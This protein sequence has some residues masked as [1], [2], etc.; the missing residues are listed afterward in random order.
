MLKKVQPLNGTDDFDNNNTDPVFL[1]KFAITEYEYYSK[2]EANQLFGCNVAGLLK[3]ITD[4]EGSTEIYTYDIYGNTK[5]YQNKS[6][7]ITTYEYNKVGWKTKEITPNQEITS[8]DY[9]KN[10]N[11][12][13]QKNPDGGIT[14]IVYDNAGYKILEVTPEQYEADKDNLQTNQY[15]GLI[16]TK[17]KWYD[18]GYLEYTEDVYGNRTTYTYDKFGNKIS[19]LR[20]NNAYY[21][22]E[23]DVLNRPTKIYFK[24]MTQQSSTEILLSETSYSILPNGNSQKT[25]TSFHD[26]DGLSKSTTTTITDY[27]GRVVEQ[28]YPDLTRTKTIYNYDGTVKEKISVNGSSTIYKYDGMGRVSD[29]WSAASIKDGNI[30]YSWNNFKYDKNGNILEQKLGKQLVGINEATDDTYSVSSKYNKGQLIEQTDSDGKKTSFEYDVNDNVKKEIKYISSTETKLTQYQYNYA[31]KPIVVISYVRNGDIIGSAFNDNSLK[32][33]ITQYIYDKNGNVKSVI[34]PDGTV[35]ANTYDKLNRLLSTSVTDNS[36]G[37]TKSITTSKIYNWDSTV[38]A[39]TD[40]NGNIT[41][42]YYDIMGNLI[43]I[44]DA[45]NNISL[46]KYD[47]AG[48]KIAEVS[49]TNVTDTDINSMERTEYTYD[50]MGRVKTKAVVFKKWNLN[51]T[52]FTWSKDWT[53]A[54][55]AAYAYDNMS[56]VIKSLDAMGFAAGTGTTDNEKIYTGYGTTNT[57]T[58]SGQ[59]ETTKD[60][61]AEFNNLPYTVKYEYNGLGQKIKETYADN[62]VISYSY[63]GSGNL[64]SS[65]VN[66]KLKGSTKYDSLGRVIETTD[67][68]GNTTLSKWNAFDKIA[69]LTAPGDDTIP[70]NTNIFQ[71]DEIGNLVYSKDSLGKANEYTYDFLNRQTSSTTR[72]VAS[73]E[74]ISLSCSYDANGNKISETNVTQPFS[75]K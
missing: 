67:G 72:N 5:T 32:S 8:W 51:K 59:L 29:A 54:V 47:L 46:A 19:E 40:A 62:T 3:K 35:V 38:E 24:D 56:N 2:T 31:G 17:Y 73:S 34:Q 4:P 20:P 28:Q 43:K 57:Y 21:R 12:I 50:S 9:D 53:R 58:L 69:E 61:E 1:D 30:K 10:G 18:N 48:R 7:N 71:Y 66:G 36:S 15:S 26:I 68:L 33:I 49:P 75:V 22:F 45:K 60:A 63:N 39:S 11:L 70:S 13:R 52:N 64:L 44:V 27:A 25:D 42:Y 74:R 37:Q 6:G 55:I 23:Y 65:Y 41:R 16:G 14:R